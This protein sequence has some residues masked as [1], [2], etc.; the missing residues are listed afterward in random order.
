MI[1]DPERMDNFIKE[2]MQMLNGER[3]KNIEPI[4]G[5]LWAQSLPY[6]MPIKPDY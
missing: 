2:F 6:S 1:L 4:C 3:G 5:G